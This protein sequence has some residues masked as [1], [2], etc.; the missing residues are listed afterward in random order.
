MTALCR[1]CDGMKVILEIGNLLLTMSYVGFEVVP[2]FR[3]Q[4]DGKK[5][6]AVILASFR[7]L[8]DGSCSIIFSLLQVVKRLWQRITSCEIILCTRRSTFNV[9]EPYREEAIV[10]SPEKR[11]P[12]TRRG[13]QEDFSTFRMTLPKMRVNGHF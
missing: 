4:F 7:R 11:K 12:R 8:I 5:T 2:S 6:A 9:G 10:K 13:H 1:H 3:S